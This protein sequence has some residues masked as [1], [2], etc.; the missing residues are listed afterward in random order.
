MLSLSTTLP[1]CSPTQCTHCKF[2]TMSSTSTVLEGVM[3]TVTVSRILL[4]S[5]HIILDTTPPP[6]DEDTIPLP[7]NT[8]LSPCCDLDVSLTTSA[9]LEILE[10]GV[11]PGDGGQ[12]VSEIPGCIGRG[13]QQRSLSQQSDLNLW[14]RQIYLFL[15]DMDRVDEYGGPRLLDR[16]SHQ[17]ALH[18]RMGKQLLLLE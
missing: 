13:Q 3:Q 1:P 10:A 7:G 5:T 12:Y 16:P 9:F 14:C 15:V 2:I 4:C 11:D 17:A 18:K 8:P 6:S